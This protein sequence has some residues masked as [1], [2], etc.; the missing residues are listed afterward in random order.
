MVSGS[1]RPCC[2]SN[3][4]GASPSLALRASPPPPDATFR[5]RHTP[6]TQTQSRREWSRAFGARHLRPNAQLDSIFPSA[7][8][9]VE[10]LLGGHHQDCMVS[11][12]RSPLQP[13]PTPALLAPPLPLPICSPLRFRGN[14]LR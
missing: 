7:A 10:L 12:R 9:A 3:N 14:C 13:Y 2:Q 5:E 4:T 6:Q 8:R 1:T 11:R